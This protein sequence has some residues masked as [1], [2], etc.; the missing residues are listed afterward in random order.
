MMSS[1]VQWTGAPAALLVD[2]VGYNAMDLIPLPR[3]A[4]CMAIGEAAGCVCRPVRHRRQEGPA[5]RVGAVCRTVVPHHI[6]RIIHRIGG[7]GN[8]RS[9]EHKTETPVTNAHIVFCLL[10]EKNTM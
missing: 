3:L 4:E 7:D 9:E 8:A 1:P 2:H 10:L 5:G 6:V